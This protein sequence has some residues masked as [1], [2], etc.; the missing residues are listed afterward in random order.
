ME[1]KPDVNAKLREYLESLTALERSEFAD[2]IGSTLG[3]LRKAI[4]ARQPLG[5][6]L[7]IA[8]ER[9]SKAAVRC[10]DLRSDV[11][12][13]YLRNSDPVPARAAS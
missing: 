5:E 11:D 13:A 7:V 10:D 2:R 1:E 8:I 6:G 3:Y 4:S 12:W 9:E